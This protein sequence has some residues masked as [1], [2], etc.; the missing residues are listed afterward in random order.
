[1]CSLGDQEC[2]P[3]ALEVGRNLGPGLQEELIWPSVA[4]NVQCLL[5]L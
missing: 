4:M 3:Q 5:K 2:K 1:M